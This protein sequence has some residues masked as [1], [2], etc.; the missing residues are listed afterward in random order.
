MKT[1]QVIDHLA[2]ELEKDEGYYYAWQSNIA[3]AFQDELARKGYR[4]P[5]QH[6]I[7]NNAAKNFL[8][9]LINTPKNRKDK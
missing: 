5:D 4:L 3:M 6:K 9:L 2:S 1:E 8:S 7:A